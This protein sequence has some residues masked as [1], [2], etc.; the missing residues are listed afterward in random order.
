MS[1]YFDNYSVSFLYIF[2][3]IFMV[4]W[5]IEVRL[6]MDMFDNQNT[7]KSQEN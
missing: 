3:S 6:E 2:Y 5:Y 7:I 1:L 4:L